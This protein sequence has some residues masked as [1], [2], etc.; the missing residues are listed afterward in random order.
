MTSLDFHEIAKLINYSRSTQIAADPVASTPGKWGLYQGHHRVRASNYQF[1]VV[2]LYSAATLGDIRA[3][4]RAAK[5]PKQTE[6]VY[7]PSL[8]RIIQNH[9][10]IAP[11]LK[12][13][14]DVF[15]SHDYLISFIKEELQTYLEKL[16][17][18][19][20]S[21]TLIHV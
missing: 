6:I 14:R 8:E 2:Y 19:R 16:R 11:L 7:A 21:S 13:F 1:F 3:A 20:Q 4:V 18:K 9:T 17:S 15:A 5:D 12:P 10:D